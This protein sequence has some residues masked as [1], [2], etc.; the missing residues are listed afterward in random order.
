MNIEVSNPDVAKELI[1]IITSCQEEYIEKIPSNIIS[2]ISKQAA[3]SFQQ[4]FI[5][6]NKPLYE[7]NL[8]EE[9]LDYFA[10]IYYMYIASK[11]EKDTILS[12]WTKNENNK[13]S[14]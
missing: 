5:D 12:N 7:Q 2:N 8:Q 4:V 11:E 6:K 9:S 3:N 1:A 10:L 13:T 14:S